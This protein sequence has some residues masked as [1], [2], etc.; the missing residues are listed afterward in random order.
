MYSQLDLEV[1]SKGYEDSQITF[2]FHKLWS[3]EFHCEK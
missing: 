2:N 1:N 3:E